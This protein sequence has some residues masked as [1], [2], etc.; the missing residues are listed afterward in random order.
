MTPTR[1]A[2]CVVLCLSPLS[3]FADEG[4]WTFNDF[5]AAKVKASYGFSPTPEW[6]DKVR[7]SSVR[8]AGGCSASLVSGSSLVMTN[9]HCAHH[10]IEQLSS[11]SAKKEDFIKNGFFAKTG[12]DEVKCPDM[13]MNQLVSITNVTKEVQAAT[14]SVAPEKFNEAQRAAIAQI[15][16]ACATSDEFRCDVVTLYRGGRYDL[17]KYR[18]FQ[19]IRLV[20]APELAIAFFGGDPD[21]FMF[22]RYDLDLSLLRIYGTDGKPMATN[23]YFP[24]SPNGASDKEL[25]FVAGNPGGTSRMLTVAQL[26]TDRDVRLPFSLTRI[27]ELRGLI[28]EYQKRGAEQK[29]HST[30]NLFGI[31]NALKAYKGR[32]AALADPTFFASLQANEADFQKKVAAKPALKKLYGSVWDDIAKVAA[33][34]KQLRKT[35]QPLE[36]GGIGDLFNTAKALV[37]YAAESPKPNGQRLREFTD[38]KLPQLKATMNAGAPIYPELETSLLGW[39]LVKLREELGPDHPVSKRL[40]DKKAPETLAKELVATTKLAD[41]KVRADLF[42]GGP[43]AIEASNDP[44]L[45]FVRSFDADARAARLRWE[46]EI[47]G[48]LKKHSERL[49]KARFEIY[50]SQQAPDATFTLR[51]SYGQV[52]GYS[53]EG[54]QVA[55]FTVFEGAYARHTGEE[56]FALPKTWLEAKAKLTPSTPFNVATTNDIIGG[57]SGSPLFNQKGEVVGL[58]F[59]GNIQSLGGDYGFDPAVNRAVAVTS[60]AILEALEKVYGATRLVNELKGQPTN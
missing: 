14:A 42:N 34:T 17:Y 51:L 2:L 12:A 27:S 37:R 22:P 8:I 45:V 32:H 31:E 29:R 49:A 52:A 47:E 19:D 60:N 38:S 21:N 39:S 40:F 57:N 28:T 41:K 53:D 4:M 25:T 13:E 48:P 30:S 35:Y 58:I 9:H 46:E 6:L 18:R 20:F 15:E 54:K 55:P 43:A 3:T 50:G 23:T 26:A 1:V 16:K 11:L 7:L 36:A 56:P 24:F 44:M 5:P 10:C 59:D 33:H